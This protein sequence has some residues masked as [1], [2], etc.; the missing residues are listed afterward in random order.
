MRSF[1][2]PT[3]L[4]RAPSYASSRYASAFHVVRPVFRHRN[5]A[6]ST[7]PCERKA[8]TS[9]SVG[10]KADPK[11]CRRNDQKS[12]GNQPRQN[13]LSLTGA[14]GE[15]DQCESSVQSHSNGQRLPSGKVAIWRAQPPD[16][17]VLYGGSQ[18]GCHQRQTGA[19]L[20][21]VKSLRD[22]VTVH[23]LRSSDDADGFGASANR[24]KGQN[25][26][27]WMGEPDLVCGPRH[28]DSLFPCA[29]ACV[30]AE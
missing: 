6:R 15:S 14:D 16:A 7:E 12:R 20:S 4:I 3:S 13:A 21:S 28:P 19:R 26:L 5:S 1:Q 29:T 17:R 24:K 18:I 23:S 10:I 30:T 27:R 22:S 8:V 2:L 11:I 25:G 9:D